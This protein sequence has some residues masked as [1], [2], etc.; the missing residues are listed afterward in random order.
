[1]LG[2][3]DAR[4]QEFRGARLGISGATV[5]YQPGLRIGPIRQL[6]KGAYLWTAPGRAWDVD[7]N[8][9]RFLMIRRPDSAAPQGSAALRPEIQ[10]VVNWAEEVKSRVP[11][12]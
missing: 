6:F 4:R 12:P 7:P 9:R 8:G 11:V 1:M 10:V 3:L 5:T 2:Q